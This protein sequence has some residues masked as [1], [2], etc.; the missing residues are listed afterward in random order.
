MHARHG[1]QQDRTS[2]AGGNHRALGVVVVLLL[3]AAFAVLLYTHANWWWYA[4]LILIGVVLAHVGIVGG[5]GFLGT[6]VIRGRLHGGTNQAQKGESDLLHNPRLFDWMARLCTLGQEDK[7]RR[8]TLDLAGLQPGDAILDVGSGTGTLLLAAAER[9][10]P[11]GVL[12]GIEPSPEMA[13]RARQKAEACRV[14][15][16]IVAASADNLPF[17]PASFDA[18]FST[19]VFHHLPKS[20][21]EDTIREMLRVLR[22]GGRVVIVDWQQPKSFLKAIMS[23]MFLT[24][25]LHNFGP[26]R[27]P[28]DAPGIES[29]MRRLGFEDIAQYSFG[30]GGGVG[31]IV[32]RTSGGRE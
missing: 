32:A 30:S 26:S 7:L 24:Y 12:R 22:P 1:F 20:M 11:S 23:P 19:L 6:R 2:H 18:A 28:L 31:A 16:E 8:W 15:L 27:S 3:G 29:L 4:P 17:P 14:P 5:I 10:G 25:L 9:V 13:S 21:Q